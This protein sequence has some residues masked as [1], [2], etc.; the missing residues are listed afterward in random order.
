MN[1]ND[2]RRALISKAAEFDMPGS[3]PDGFDQAARTR[4]A[5][6]AVRVGAGALAAIVV[7]VSLMHV[8]SVRDG[9]SKTKMPVTIDLVGDYVVEDH[10]GRDSIP[11]RN[12]V[13][14]HVA[15]MRRQ[16]FDLPRP[17]RSA[18]GWS[19]NVN[20]P[21]QLGV[22][23]RE[24][25]EAAFVTCAP[26]PPP[27]PGDLVL[28]GVSAERI[29]EFRGCME[30]QGFTLRPPVQAARGWRFH[31]RGEVDFGD[32]RWNRAVFVTCGV[33]FS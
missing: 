23:S 22:G 8:L 28:P 21:E 11:S 29:Q 31:T 20:D 7:G 27:G 24:W 30:R 9:S 17:V 2:L 33:G 10:G 4:L 18:H 3:V 14:Q 12:E 19:I 32:R 5:R 15:C 6:A 13:D 26:S 1:A 25:R 16:G